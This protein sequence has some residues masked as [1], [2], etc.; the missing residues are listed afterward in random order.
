MRFFQKTS[1]NAEILTQELNDDSIINWDIAKGKSAFVVIGGDRELVLPINAQKGDEL[2]LMIEQDQTGGHGIILG[3][4][5]KLEDDLIFQ[6]AYPKTAKTVLDISFD[7]EFFL[8]KKLA[9]FSP[10]AEK[11][12]EHSTLINGLIAFYEFN[13]DSYN[14]IDGEVIDSHS[15]HSGKANNAGLGFVED[16][17]RGH[18]LFLDGIDYHDITIPQDPAFNYSNGVTF[19][20]WIKPTELQDGMIF[21]QDYT[22]LFLPIN[23]AKLRVRWESGYGSSFY[24]NDELNINEWVMLGVDWDLATNKGRVFINGELA[25]E[26][27]LNSPNDR[28]NYPIHIGSFNGWDYRFKGYLDQF[29][30]WNRALTI[31]EWA[32]LYA[33]GQGLNY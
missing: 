20:A 21:G 1:P 27:S 10:E 33:N 15:I 29:A 4:G 18:V 11:I 23:N 3:A 7:G 19:N 9:R 25:G 26:A 31:Q 17:E 24:I 32:D 2:R 16:S 5:W 14:S 12:S 28:S 8:I 13:E 22:D 30:L 6:L